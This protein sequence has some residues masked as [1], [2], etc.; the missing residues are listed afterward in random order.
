VERFGNGQGWDVGA[1]H[2]DDSFDVTLAG[3][4]QGTVRW[5]LMGEHNRQ[6][7]LAAIAAARHSGVPVERAIDSLGRF[8]GVKRRME[9]RGAVNGIT[10]YDDFAHHP[11]A[12]ETTIA[13]LR[14]RVGD[15]RIVAVFEPRSNTMKLGTMQE[16]LASSL[17][18]AD[19]VFCYAKDLGWDPSQALT[20]LGTR[21]FTHVDMGTMVESMSRM[22]QPGDHVLV[23]SNGGFGNVH[24]KIL[25]RLASSGRRAR[26]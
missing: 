2:P 1:I 8:E 26:A 24:Q 17:A 9:M 14:R 19:L 21:V 6:N 11:T 16:R 22:L 7:A 5:A 23:M 18:D 12:F 10:V 20:T 15:A 4:R 3:A 25:E 13:G